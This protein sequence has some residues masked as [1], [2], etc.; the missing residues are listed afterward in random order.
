MGSDL[1]RL[2]GILNRTDIENMEENIVQID[3]SDEAY[4][5]RYKLV[6]ERVAEFP[7]SLTGAAGEYF[8]AVKHIAELC[9]AERNTKSHSRAVN[10]ALYAELGE[11]G[12]KDSF[13]NTEYAV[14][15]FGSIGTLLSVWYAEF[16]G[17]IPFTFEN[18]IKDVTVI[19]ETVMQLYCAFEEKGTAEPDEAFFDEI[20]EIIYSYIYDY[21]DEFV[22][23]YIARETE[24][25][26]SF[27]KDIVMNADL[28]DLGDDSYLY[29]YGEYITDEE[30]L[31][32]KLM[33]K[34]SESDIERMARAYTRGYIKGFAMTGKDISKK[35]VVSCYLPIGLE[36]FMRCAVKQF[37]EA[38]LKCVINRNPVHLINKKNTANIK[39]GFYG[40]CNPECDYDH[41]EDMALF[42]GDK[43]KAKKLEALKAAYEAHADMLKEASGHACVEIF[44]RKGREPRVKAENAAFS[45]HQ[46]KV[47]REY[48]FKAHEIAEAYMPD[49]EIS[50]TI[51]AWPTPSIAADISEYKSDEGFEH[52]YEEIFREIIDINTLPEEKWQQIQQKLIDALDTADYV[53]IKGTP[54]NETDIR[55]SLHKLEDPDKQTNFEN[56]LSDVN[57]PA[58]EVFTSPVLK[59][60]EGKLHAGYAYIGGYLFKDLKICFENGRVSEYSCANYEDIEQGRELIRKVIFK[61]REKLPMGEFAIGTNTVAYAAADKFGIADKMPVLIAEKTGPHFAVGD[62][63][64]SYE[65]DIATF[66]P[67]GKQIVARENECS[68]LRKTDPEQAYF[69]VHT[70]ITL[71]YSE[72][73]LIRAVNAENTTDI[74]RNGRFVLPGTEELNEAL[75][76]NE[77]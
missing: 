47:T 28:S 73:G 58:G 11:E 74:I 53:E 41:K 48:A 44:G 72:L 43:L 35:S 52:R 8:S 49:E 71:P 50:F 60:T 23:A 31:T 39:P 17:I 65:E 51:I 6:S 22:E 55:V 69:A 26:Y 10:E 29:S 40:A 18:R 70:D 67:D 42:W 63:C 33:N 45:E 9:Y 34:L 46:K 38:G 27:A 24:P 21:T 76:K 15:R 62:T 5:E 19:L 68:A 61:D 66:N 2:N 56:C 12:Y 7:G 1:C 37:E 4:E 20:N 32:A 25:G 16:R 13:L 57:I 36:R 64:Y 77:E 75:D 3:F 59:G 30:R 14:K 54:G